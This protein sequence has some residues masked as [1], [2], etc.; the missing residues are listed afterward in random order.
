MLK[1]HT[2]DETQCIRCIYAYQRGGFLGWRGFLLRRYAC[3][4]TRE[5]ITR[6]KHVGLDPL[7]HTRVCGSDL[8]SRSIKE[9]IGSLSES[10]V[11]VTFISLS[12]ADKS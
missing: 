1:G 5:K 11:S 12:R 7:P 6:H 2:L 9:E 10:S 4:T 3:E 8:A